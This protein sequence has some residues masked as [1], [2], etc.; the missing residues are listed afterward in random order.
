MLSTSPAC[1]LTSCRWFWGCSSHILR[2]EFGRSGLDEACELPD[3]SLY[4]FDELNKYAPAS[5]RGQETTLLDQVLDISERGRS[6]AS[7]VLRPAILECVHPR[8][9]ATPPLKC[10]GAP[11]APKTTKARIAS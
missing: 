9:T 6:F 7:S 1:S 4:L 8:V 10:L 3:K 11:T 2:A 5:A